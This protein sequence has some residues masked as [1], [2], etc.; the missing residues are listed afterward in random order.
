MTIQ[1]WGYKSSS[2]GKFE[3]SIDHMNEQGQE[4]WECCGIHFTENGAINK[5]IW[6]CPIK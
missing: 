5:I 4:G 1:K 2:P 6:K 3:D